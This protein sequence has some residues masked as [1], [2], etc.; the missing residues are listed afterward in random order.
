MQTISTMNDISDYTEAHKI[1]WSVQIELLSLCNFSCKHCYIPNRTSKGIP[2]KKIKELAE[3][4]FEMGVFDVTL[5]GGEIFLRDDILEIVE[6]FRS[7]GL[8]VQLFSNGSLLNREVCEK[9]KSLGIYQFSTTIFSLDAEINDYITCHRNSLA[10]ILSNISL[11]QEYEIPIEIK[12]PIMKSN[13][14]SYAGLKKY[15]HDN[16]FGFFP[17]ACI[18]PKTDGDPAPLQFELEDSDFGKISREIRSAP[19]NSSS[20]APVPFDRDETICHSLFNSVF[21]DSAGNVFP[22]ISWQ[23]KIGNIYEKSIEDIWANS[24][25]LHYLRTLKKSDMKFCGKC[26]YSSSCTICPGDSMA[27]GDMLGCSSLEKKLAKSILG[28]I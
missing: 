16:N 11:L 27:D 24:E 6:A 13:Y 22:C 8:R 23:I 21:I 4:F 5:T 26:E 2:L 15:C 1:L 14:S 20:S 18:S 25:M 19:S 3:S 12:M 28:L 17:S 10:T 9:L 7:R